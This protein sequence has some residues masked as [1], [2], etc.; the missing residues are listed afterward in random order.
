MMVFADNA[1]YA[2]ENKALIAYDN[3]I[4]SVFLD[5]DDNPS[6]PIRNTQDTYTYTAYRYAGASATTIVINCVMSRA[7][8]YVAI[9]CHN[10]DTAAGVI[11]VETTG[12]SAKFLANDRAPIIVHTG[13]G[14][15]AGQAIITIADAQPGLQIG[16]I[17]AGTLLQMQRTAYQGF[18]PPSLNRNQERIGSVSDTGQ[19]LGQLVT[20][21]MYEASPSWDD[22]TPGWYRDNIEPFALATSS[23]P[24]VIA[25]RPADFPN[26]LVYG[27]RTG[28]VS[29][30]NTGPAGL[31]SVS[32]E[33]QA[34][35]H[36][37]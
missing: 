4:S 18:T 21:T 15:T 7:P 26:D 27:W 35:N 37:R 5:V 6:S 3:A 12:G 25:W 30:K 34:V 20:R 1:P 36:D 17:T 28:D 33:M 10:F 19:Y 24:F 13:Q 8:D 2:G 29:P 9:A 16:V 22:L 14:D 11:T 31:M 23:R 32:F